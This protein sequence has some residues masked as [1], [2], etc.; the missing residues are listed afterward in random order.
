MAYKFVTPSGT[1]GYPAFKRDVVAM[2]KEVKQANLVRT[3]ESK[4]LA[5]KAAKWMSEKVK[6][7]IRRRSG[8]TGELQESLLNSVRF[9]R[10]MKKGF[11]I[12]VGS[13]LPDYW[14]MINYGGVIMSG[15]VPG[16]WDDSPGGVSW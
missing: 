2:Q 9:R 4:V 6:R 10:S 14:A 7:K 1:P 16:F 12:S 8:S 11:Y 13:D 5:D 3:I 15:Y